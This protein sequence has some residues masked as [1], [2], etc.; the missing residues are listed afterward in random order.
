MTSISSSSRLAWILVLSKSQFCS[1]RLTNPSRFLSRESK[2][3]QR[4]E[5][6]K[7]IIAE[8]KGLVMASPVNGY[9]VSTG[10]PGPGVSSGSSHCLVYS[11]KNSAETAGTSW[12]DRRSRWGKESSILTRSCLISLVSPDNGS[13]GGFDDGAAAGLV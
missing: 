8:A 6:E 11:R 3:L 12:N 5:I 9:D 13:A 1:S 7:E 2:I 10:V 4:G